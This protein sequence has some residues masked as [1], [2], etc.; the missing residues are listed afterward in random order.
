LSR[1][2]PVQLLVTPVTEKWHYWDFSTLTLNNH[3]LNNVIKSDSYKS[4][5]HND[6]RQQQATKSEKNKRTLSVP[7]SWFHAL[8]RLENGLLG[9]IRN[10]LDLT[11]GVKKTGIS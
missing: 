3:T 10:S 5:M 1:H 6:N 9:L 4:D 11:N 8:Y 7:P 2:G